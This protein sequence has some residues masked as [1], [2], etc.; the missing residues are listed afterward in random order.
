MHEPDK[1]HPDGPLGELLL[2]DS[3]WFVE[4]A[5]VVRESPAWLASG[6]GGRSTPMTPCGAATAALAIGEDLRKRWIE[7]SDARFTGRTGGEAA[8]VAEAER[9]GELAS[10]SSSYSSGN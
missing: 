8:E 4:R 5:G 2:A 6:E 7:D 1:T 10:A 3:D 9:V